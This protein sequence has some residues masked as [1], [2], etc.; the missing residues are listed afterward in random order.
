MTIE[1]AIKARLYP[2]TLPDA[3][4]ELMAENHGLDIEDDYSKDEHEITLARIE[5]EGLWQ[6]ITLSKEQDN[7]STQEYNVK[8]IEKRIRRVA[9]LYGLDDELKGIMPQNEDMTA[10]W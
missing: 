2:Y 10:Y 6:L 3:S 9:G 1:Q 4:I 8:L 5:I 7:G